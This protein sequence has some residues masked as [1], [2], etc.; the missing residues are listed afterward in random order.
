MPSVKFRD[1]EEE[2][3][4]INIYRQ[5]ILIEIKKRGITQKELAARLMLNRNYFYLM[6]NPSLANM[7]RVATAIGCKFTDLTKGI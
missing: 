2:A 1:K 7:V 5:N 4:I 6:Y 3:R